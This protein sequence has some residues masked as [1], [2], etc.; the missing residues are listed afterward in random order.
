MEDN[1]FQTEKGLVLTLRPV[2]EHIVGMALEAIE[3]E[4]RA[5]GEAINPPTYTTSAGQ[6]WPHQ[7]D[8]HVDTLTVEGDAAQ[9][10]ANWAA[11]NR[12]VD[13]RDRLD[14]A[15][16]KRRLEIMLALGVED[17]VIPEDGWREEQ[18]WAGITEFPTDPRK[19]KA[20]YLQTVVL[21]TAEMQ[22]VLAQIMALANVPPD[23]RELFRQAAERA[24]GKSIRSAFGESEA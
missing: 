16:G 11:W 8:E 6:T 20:Y 21:T 2:K 3:A 15:K 24:V 23:Q 19:L 1:Q 12:Y 22:I 7:H 5:K 13:A 10:A 9:T 18:E 17:F 14:A 4:W